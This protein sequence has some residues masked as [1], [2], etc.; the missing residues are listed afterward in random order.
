MTIPRRLPKGAVDV[1]V[2]ASGLKVYGEGEW[3][4]RQPGVGRRRTW[5]KLHL[6]VDP[7][8]H[9]VVAAELTLGSVTD[10]EIFPD[11]LDQLGEQELGK[12]YGD[13]AYDQ[14]PCF[15]AILERNA[16]P[17]TP[18]RKDAVECD[19]HPPRTQ[20]VR[21]CPGEGGRAQWKRAVGYHRR[22]LSETALYRYQ[23]LI[24]A[25]MRARRCDTQQTEP[26]AAIAVLNRLN[27]LGMPKR[28]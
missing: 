7:A 13:G 28:A 17:I 11:L 14:G 24:G 15:E 2:D 1:V 25:A 18:P 12:V 16:T 3:K 19:K 20:A 9:D 27:T 6:G 23:Q 8:T 22:S 5:R 10:G 4:V 21:A 26:H